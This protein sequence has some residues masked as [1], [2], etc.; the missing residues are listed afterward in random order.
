MHGEQRITER[1]EAIKNAT[2]LTRD[3]GIIMPHA[4]LVQSLIA[5]LRATL[6]GAQVSV[7]GGLA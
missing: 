2:P 4:L 7:G 3:E 6:V 5:Q 1:L